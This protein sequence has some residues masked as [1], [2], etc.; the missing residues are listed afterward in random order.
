MM[1]A[2]QTD[3][4]VGAGVRVN[5]FGYAVLELAAVRPLDRPTT[6]WIFGFRLTRGY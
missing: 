3:H 1:P 4:G 5:A 2:I 6:G